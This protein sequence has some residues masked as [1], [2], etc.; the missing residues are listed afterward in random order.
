MIKL[1]ALLLALA[2]ALVCLPGLA[3]TEQNWYL[4]TAWTLTED[5]AELADDDAYIQ[6]L[7][8]LQSPYPYSGAD[9]EGI[10]GAWEIGPFRQTTLALLASTVGFVSGE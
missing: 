10:A 2:L 4:D 8:Y 9:F 7:Y 3:E 6:T 5:I 1:L